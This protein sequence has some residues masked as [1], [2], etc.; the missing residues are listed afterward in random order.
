[1][2][3]EDIWNAFL[4]GFKLFLVSFVAGLV[5]LIPKLLAMGVTA[6]AALSSMTWLLSVAMVLNILVWIFGIIAFG[7][8]VLKWKNWIF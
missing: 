7:W 6:L 3:F 4:I 5:A 8:L 2:N 1:M